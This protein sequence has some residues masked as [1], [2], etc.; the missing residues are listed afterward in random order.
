MIYD[1]LRL[2]LLGTLAFLQFIPAS[3]RGEQ[4]ESPGLLLLGIHLK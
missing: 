3:F 4:H 1:D 2:Q